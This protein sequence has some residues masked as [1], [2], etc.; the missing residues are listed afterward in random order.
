M[1]YDRKWSPWGLGILCALLS[2]ACSGGGE[3]RALHRLERLVFVPERGCTLLPETEQ[4]VDCT[5][6]RPLLVDRFEVTQ[7]EWREWLEGLNENADAQASL[8]YWTEVH[9]SYPA[10]GMTLG[11]ARDFAVLEGMR[12]PTSREW[13]RIAV[14]TRAQ[15][16]PWGKG[17]KESVANTLELRLGRR[18][19]V[20][21]FES[22]STPSGVYDLVG[23][24]S[25]WVID[26]LRPLDSRS[27]QRAWAFGG[28]YLDSKKRSYWLDEGADI[29]EDG[30]VDGNTSFNSI[31]V[32]PLH[33]GRGLG[34][35][36]VADAEDWLELASKEWPDD[37]ARLEAVGRKWGSAAVEVL[38]RLAA[39]PDV[40]VGIEHL[41]RGARQ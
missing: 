30:A 38:E 35:R 20:G 4:P 24:A 32:E 10:T 25:E 40:G 18:A 8:D 19:P 9:P 1:G 17:S 12:L 41:L 36:L 7:S 26:D 33:R 15:Y 37:P 5:N 28:S 6:E 21:C 39:K 13:L 34:M 11:E 31:L 2:T 3:E 23:N 27:D 29:D 16:F 22:G 14:G